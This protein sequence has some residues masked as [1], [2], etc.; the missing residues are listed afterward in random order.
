MAKCKYC[1]RAS[2][3]YVEYCGDCYAK[4]CLIRKIRAIGGELLE[5]REKDRQIETWR[6]YCKTW[7]GDD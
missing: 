6:K 5:M 1:G 2:K 3:R 4:I 7:K